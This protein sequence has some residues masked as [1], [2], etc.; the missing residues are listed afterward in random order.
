M[1][2]ILDEKS[3][4]KIA[5]GEVIERPA[6]VVKELIEN[7]IDAGSTSVEVEVRASGVNLVRVAD[8]GCGMSVEDAEKACLAH[9]TSK[10]KDASELESVKTLGFRGEGLSSIAAVSQIDLITCSQDAETGT[11]LYLEN[12][13]ITS[14]RPT[15]RAKG[16]TI[17]VRNL[18]YN[19]PARKKFL[20]KEATELSEIVNVFGRFILSHTDIEFKLSHGD[21]VLLHAT[22]DMD[23]ASR[24]G[25][26]MGEDVA[27]SSLAIPETKNRYK[28]RGLVSTPAATR[29]DRKS[30]IFFINGRF[31]KSRVLND[32]VYDAYRSMLERGRHPSAVIFMNVPTSQI[33]VNVHPTKLQVKFNEENSVRKEL[34]SAIKA[35][36]VSVK[37][38]VVSIPEPKISSEV[39]ADPVVI[40]SQEEFTYT[41]NIDKTS[42]DKGEAPRPVKPIEPDIQAFNQVS[43][44]I[45]QVGN[46][47]IVQVEDDGMV[48]TDQ[49]AAHE[50][51]LYE[52]FSESILSGKIDSQ[53]LLFPVK[54][55]LSASQV[56]VMDKITDSF[57]PLGFQIEH[58]GDR[59]Y[60]VQAV[61]AVI[62]DSDIKTVVYDILSDISE[63]DLKKIDVTDELI[64]LTACRAAIKAGDPLSKREMFY[65]LEQLKGCDLPFTCPHGRPTVLN[66]TVEELEKRFRRT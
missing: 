25:L 36:F 24:V 60:V 8:N 6:S 16:T 49:H 26:V 62:K 30:Q 51:V 53:N 33:D 14:K 45:F 3:I 1:I 2:N 54:L 32:A 35:A 11:Y 40:E 12:G 27:L 38:E 39:I 66:V 47:Y 37:E 22:C 18:F 65:L 9:A 7:S 59:S 55:E 28:I 4:N 43:G 41:E 42:L 31:V 52:L 21:R 57:R 19:V 56:I 63:M 48:I 20:R 58:F 61:P 34:S 44:D 46:C 50:R 5:A 17:E 29:K 13:K 15:G 64:K 10:I 23:L